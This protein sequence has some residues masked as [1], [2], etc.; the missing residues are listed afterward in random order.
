MAPC[1]G[2]FSSKEHQS[3]CLLAAACASQ[4][5]TFFKTYF[6]KSSPDFKKY[7]SNQISLGLKRKIQIDGTMWLSKKHS[8]ETKD[9][10][11]NANKIKQHGSKNSQYGTLWVCNISE[12]INKKIKNKELENYLELGWLQGRNKWLITRKTRYNKEHHKNKRILVLEKTISIFKE[13]LSL[14]ATSLFLNVSSSTVVK[15]IR[16][17]EKEF[18]THILVDEPSKIFVPPQDAAL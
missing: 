8:Q 11:G 10:I 16:E 14:T 4:G 6:E 2:G 17:Y 1:G 3:K 9:A 18:N 12:K 13:T 15:R 7:F 5:N